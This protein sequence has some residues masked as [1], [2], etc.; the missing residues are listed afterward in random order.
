[1]TDS[2]LN[3]AYKTSF[4]IVNDMYLIFLFCFVSLP[5]SQQYFSRVRMGLPGLKQ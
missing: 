5:P 1:M 2:L 3:H 4:L